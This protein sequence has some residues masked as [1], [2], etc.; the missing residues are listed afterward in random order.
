VAATELA[1]LMPVIILLVLLPVQAGLWWH[2][3]QTV[4]AAAE[5][6]VD[7]AQPV[8]ASTADGHA[9]AA[10]ITRSS[11]V[12]RNVTVDVGRSASLATATVHADLGFS[13]FPGSWAVT[14]YA[15]GPVEAFIAE[16]DR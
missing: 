2:A 4:Q 12:L 9:G 5:E 6:A 7:A 15:E 10:V 13:L 8:G 3:K 16:D 1:V 14:G 11:G